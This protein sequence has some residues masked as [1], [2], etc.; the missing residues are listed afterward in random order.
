MVKSDTFWKQVIINKFRLEE[1]E[2]CSRVARRG[3]GVGVWKA[4]RKEWE[5]IC[6]RY[7]FIVKNGKKVKIWKDL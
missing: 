5:G 1:G 4:I 6:C 3:Y 7:R 2:W